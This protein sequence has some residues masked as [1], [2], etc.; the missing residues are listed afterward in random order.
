LDPTLA[1]FDFPNPNASAE[2]R[3][4]TATP[5]QQLF[6]LNSSFIEQRAAALASRADLAG[7]GDAATKVQRLYRLVLA[8]PARADELAAC[9]AFVSADSQT[10]SELAKLLLS[11]N[12]F[13]FLN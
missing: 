3:L 11:S 9:L 1:L 8:R 12:E 10:W 6:F 13:V 7:G 5:L 2:Q 4:T